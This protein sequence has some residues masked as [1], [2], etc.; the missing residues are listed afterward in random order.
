MKEE[1]PISKQQGCFSVSRVR[2]V[3]EFLSTLTRTQA[4]STTTLSHFSFK[5]TAWYISVA[6]LQNVLPHQFISA[7]VKIVE[8]VYF[9]NTLNQSC[10]D[11]FRHQKAVLL[12]EPHPLAALVQ[13]SGSELNTR[14]HSLVHPFGKY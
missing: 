7:E 13:I 10:F 14:I 1:K 12:N 5:S 11:F 9:A 8:A 4:R 3:S 6:L 2:P